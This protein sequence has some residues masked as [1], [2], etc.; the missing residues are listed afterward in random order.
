MLHTVSP[1]ILKLSLFLMTAVATHLVMSFG[2]TLLHIRSRTWSG[3]WVA[4]DTFCMISSGRCVVAI[5]ATVP[6][7][8]IGFL[9][10][11]D[12]ARANDLQQERFLGS[13]EFEFDAPQIR[14]HFRRQKMFVSHVRP[15]I[16]ITVTL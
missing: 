6:I 16:R 9:T 2:Q 12:P 13:L 11:V 3:C 4:S 5:R 7:V 8:V 1:L 15:P 14:E 10:D